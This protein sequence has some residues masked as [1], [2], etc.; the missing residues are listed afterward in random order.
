MKH[1]TRCHLRQK[2]YSF[3]DLRRD[4]KLAAMRFLSTSPCG[5]VTP[6]ESLV[7]GLST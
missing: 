2:D 1:A 4:W 3:E 6:D 5:S 7:T